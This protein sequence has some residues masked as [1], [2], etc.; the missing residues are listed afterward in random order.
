MNTYDL[1]NVS[2]TSHHYFLVNVNAFHVRGSGLLLT[3]VID[4]FCTTKL[5]LLRLV[6]TDSAHIFFQ[7]VKIVS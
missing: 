7:N 5:F 4:F 2:C 6:S 1:H 3:T